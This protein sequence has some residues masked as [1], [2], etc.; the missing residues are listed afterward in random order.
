MRAGRLAA[1]EDEVDGL[2]E[3]AI[4][5]VTY[6]GSVPVVDLPGIV[7]KRV[8]SG[9]LFRSR[10]PQRVRQSLQVMLKDSI[11][12]VDVVEDAEHQH[13]ILA[14]QPVEAPTDYLI[15]VATGPSLA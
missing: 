10:R 9:H 15:K 1:G 4:R 12:R 6:V 11:D 13:G 7:R 5:Q 2:L 14:R 3:I 8:E